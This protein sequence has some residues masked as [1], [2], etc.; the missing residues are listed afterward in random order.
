MLLYGQVGR[1][2]IERQGKK[3]SGGKI[4]GCSAFPEMQGFSP[5]NPKYM[6]AFGE[7]WPGQMRNSLLQKNFWCAQH[8]LRA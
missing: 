8:G 1:D 5:R 2:I 6:R 4:A 7:V 3:G